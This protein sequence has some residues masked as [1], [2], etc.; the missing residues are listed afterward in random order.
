[1]VAASQSSPASVKANKADE[2]V[3]IGVAGTGDL[4]AE[5]AAAIPAG[6][7]VWLAIG[8]T[9]FYITSDSAL[10]RWRN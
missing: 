6:A 4:S 1:M 7:R 10:E 3:P 8:H 2:R 9:D 5:N